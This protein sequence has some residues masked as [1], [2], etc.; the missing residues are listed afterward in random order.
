MYHCVGFNYDAKY[1]V[2]AVPDMWV[3]KKGILLWPPKGDKA[4][5]LIN[6]HSRPQPNWRKLTYEKVYA[7]NLGS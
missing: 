5:Q 1:Y 7:K 2:Q 6:S 3:Q 4:R